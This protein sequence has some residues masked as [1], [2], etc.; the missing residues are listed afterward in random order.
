MKRLVLIA[1][2]LLCL[3]F[4][5]APL[6]AQKGKSSSAPKTVAVKGYTTK[7]GKKVEPYTRAAPEPK[8]SG[9]SSSSSSA[10]TPK[11]ATTPK[12]SSSSTA[13]APKP[14]PTSSAAC[15]TCPRDKDGKIAR[16]EAAKETFMKQTGFPKGRPGWV[17]DH[18]YPLACGGLDAPSNMQWQTEAQAKAK[19]KI[20]RKGCS[21]LPE[22]A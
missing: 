22:A 3:F 21:P 10:S 4:A 18:I 1:A 15:A 17:V 16:S 7:D 8:P 5:H 11:P 14:A 19:D 12:P 20:E 6:D 13:A 2:S 9:S